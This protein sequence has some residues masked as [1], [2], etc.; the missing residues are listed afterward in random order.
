MWRWS[1][2]GGAEAGGSSFCFG[3]VLNFDDL[4]VGNGCD[5]HLRDAHMFFDREGFAAEV[6]E[7]YFDFAAVI[8]VDG[9]GRIG[10]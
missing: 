7:W 5:D 4:C 6:D 3:E 1:V 10:H 8:G 2:A 9:A